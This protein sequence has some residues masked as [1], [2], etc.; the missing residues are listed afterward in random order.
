MWIFTG[1]IDVNNV[2]GFINTDILWSIKEWLTL[3]KDYA[4]EL[5]GRY[6]QYNIIMSCVYIW[7]GLLLLAIALYYLPAIFRACKKVSL[8]SYDDWIQWIGFVC[9]I[10]IVIWIPL[11]ATISS[12]VELIKRKVIPEIQLYQSVMDL[13][14]SQ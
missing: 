11:W 14:N 8:S 1:Q 4:L 10:L 5:G 7:I 13:K 6:I 12:T 2:L 3:T 9:Y